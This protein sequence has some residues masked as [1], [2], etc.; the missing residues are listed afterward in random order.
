MFSS[1]FLILCKVTALSDN[2]KI[3]KKYFIL[4]EDFIYVARKR[5]TTSEFYVNS[6]RKLF[7]FLLKNK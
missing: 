7:V 1:S 2:N 6:T 3:K 4:L 5:V